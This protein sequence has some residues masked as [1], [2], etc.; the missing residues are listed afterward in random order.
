MNDKELETL[1]ILQRFITM[2]SISN[3]L[4]QTMIPR[5]LCNSQMIWLYKRVKKTMPI[6]Q[7]DE[8]IQTLK[9]IEKDCTDYLKKNGVP[10][11]VDNYYLFVPVRTTIQ[12]QKFINENKFVF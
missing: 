11:Y 9:S 1:A 7:H 2:K 8:M 4:Q 6:E 3:V 5:V 12:L 10:L